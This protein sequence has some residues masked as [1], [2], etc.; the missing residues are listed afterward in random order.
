LQYQCEANV[1]QHPIVTTYFPI[2]QQYIFYLAYMFLLPLSWCVDLAVFYV[3]IWHHLYSYYHL[4]FCVSSVVSL[5]THPGGRET[6]RE[7]HS[8]TRT[9]DGFTCTTC[10]KSF[11]N[12]TGIERHLRSHTGEKPFKC[13]I[14]PYRATIYFNL[15]QHVE[16]VHPGTY[17]PRSY[18]D[19]E[20]KYKGYHYY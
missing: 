17:I 12:M 8:F 2:F 16:N 3:S 5:R 15:K 20:E 19:F 4:Q 1:Y 7:N 9:Q 10:S 13:P 18:K 14:C 6:T 11:P